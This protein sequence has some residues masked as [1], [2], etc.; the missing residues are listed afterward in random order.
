MA[1]FSG[2]PAADR[3]VGPG[4]AYI[5]DDREGCCFCGGRCAGVRPTARR[6]TRSAMLLAARMKRPVACAKWK[7][8][9]V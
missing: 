5:L 6:I 2:S 9:R 3:H 1:K 7:N 8:S 4:C